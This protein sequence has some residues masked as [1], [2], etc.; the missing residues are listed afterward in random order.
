MD[1]RALVAIAVGMTGLVLGF[2]ALFDGGPIGLF[3]GFAALGAGIV[4]F[5]TARDLGK[6]EAAVEQERE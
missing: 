1:S 6:A 5:L 4:G 2:I 3:A